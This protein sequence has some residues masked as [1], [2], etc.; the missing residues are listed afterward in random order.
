MT[1]TPFDEEAARAYLRTH[2]N[3]PMTMER[4]AAINKIIARMER[5]QE[6]VARKNKRR[7]DKRF[8]DAYKA[9]LGAD[10]E[11]QAKALS[12]IMRPVLN[13]K[14]I[15]PPKPVP[16]AE[17]LV[18]ILFR[19]AYLASAWRQAGYSRKHHA[20][21]GKILI[22]PTIRA[23]VIERLNA[24]GKLRGKLH[25]AVIDKLGWRPVTLEDLI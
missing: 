20:S 9:N 18:D 25:Q 8:G 11:A 10:P 12:R 13:P 21:I 15:P 17:K 23:Y 1:D 22:S 6:A 19:G 14:I 24:G 16:D 7:K 2:R 5:S 3:T 4:Q